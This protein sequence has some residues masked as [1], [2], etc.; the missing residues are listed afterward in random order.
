[1]TEQDKIWVTI[2]QWVSNMEFLSTMVG[3]DFTLPVPLERENQ[4][5]LLE[6]MQNYNT[7]QAKEYNRLRSL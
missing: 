4:Q 5:T 6:F 2:C 1:M 7:N 3:M